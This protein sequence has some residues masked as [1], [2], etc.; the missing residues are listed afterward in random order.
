V[1]QPGHN[2]EPL[3]GHLQHTTLS[4][5]QYPGY[6]ALSYV[7][8]DPSTTSVLIIDGHESSI[9]KN[10][11]YASRHLRSEVEPITL[12][13]DAVCVNQSDVAERN[14][15]V[16]RMGLIY[17][18]AKKVNIWL[19]PAT[20][21][22]AIG[23]E[24]LSYLATH[25]TA[26]DSPP[27]KVIPSYLVKAGLNDIMSREWFQRIWVVQEAA[28]SRTATMISGKH[29]FSW[30]GTDVTLVY[31]FISRIK[32]AEISP[33]WEQAGLGAVDMSPLLDL[34][35]LQI[36]R[37]LERGHGG[38]HRHPRDLLD[39]VHSMRHKI[40]TDPRDKVFGLLGVPVTYDVEDFNVDYAMTVEE[41]YLHLRSVINLG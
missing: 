32:F 36:G 12:W 20:P 3:C 38:N 6:D 28:A 35:D 24:I 21:D 31:R 30:V 25:K 29:Q 9:T 5:K 4:G 39:V 14:S 27:W 18:F 23:I 7:W 2:S 8:G 33:Q 13:I 37:Q 15:Q 16:R 26:A 41:T 10:L 1:L 19:G 17:E 40:S 11:E 22:C 34:L